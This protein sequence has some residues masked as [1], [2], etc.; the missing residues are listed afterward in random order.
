MR[1]RQ[2]EVT[3][4][5]LLQAAVT[6]VVALLV[7]VAALLS[8]DA[9]SAWQSSVRQEIRRSAAIIESVRYVYSDEA[10]VALEVALV[11]SRAARL[12]DGEG[13]AARRVAA[14]L[15]QSHEGTDHIL[16]TPRYRLEGGGY[17]LARRL[18]DVRRA[19][20]DLARINPDTALE[21]GDRRSDLASILATLTIPV[22]LLYVAIEAWARIRQRRRIPEPASSRETPDQD[23]MDVG[24][25]PRPWSV[26]SARRLGVALAFGAWLIVTLLPGPQLRFS[27]EEQRAQSM[28]ARLGVESST[29]VFASSL[30]NSFQIT[31][32]QRLLALDLR[33]GAMLQSAMSTPRPELRDALVA[34]AG[35]A[36]VAV[37]RSRLATEPM[38]RTPSSA[39]GVDKAAL[40]AVT[41]S[42]PRAFAIVREQNRTVEDAEIAGQRANRSGLALLL[43]A[44][45][46]SLA[47]LGAV[48]GVKGR[49]AIERSAA[50]VLA[51][52][53][54]AAASIVV[55]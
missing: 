28:A 33:G 49:G 12:P 24:L 6:L 39:D 16:G 13:D 35:R 36:I 29:A 10:A 31:T 19:S 2:S 34:E 9:T 52:A 54:L 14:V 46:L 7:T 38:A 18:A 45:A 1:Q 4:S 15:K 50:V 11:E 41:T 40:T 23:Q 42:L 47:T 20:A 55:A 5:N 21:R 32:Q 27:N 25:I 53:F 44:L 48:S 43:A 37:K 8:S 17:D 26:P 30:L 22:V 3:G 51:G